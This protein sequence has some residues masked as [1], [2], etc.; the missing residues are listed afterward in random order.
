MR[1]VSASSPLEDRVHV[2]PVA[3]RPYGDRLCLDLVANAVVTHPDF[4]EA[5]QRTPKALA[6]SSWFRHQPDLDR[7]DD[8]CAEVLRD[9]RKVFLHDFWPV[10]QRIGGVHQLPDAQP[11]LELLMGDRGRGILPAS[12][13]EFL[14]R[15]VFPQLQSLADELANLLRE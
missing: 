3:D 9:T 13:D 12:V 5:G 8:S 6:V 4:P 14:Q 7:P 2:A 11:P 10:Q 15:Y 1:L